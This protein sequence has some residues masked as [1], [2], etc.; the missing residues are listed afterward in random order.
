MYDKSQ[1]RPASIFSQ[2]RRA[3]ATTRIPV[4]R[5]FMELRVSRNFSSN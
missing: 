1:V 5:A 3:R 2:R 4:Y